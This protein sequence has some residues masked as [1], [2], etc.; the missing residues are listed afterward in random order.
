MKNFQK[1]YKTFIGVGEIQVLTAASMKMT[2]LQ[3][4]APFILVETDQHFR[5][6]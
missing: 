1:L 2:V 6:D 4:V 3:D 5:G